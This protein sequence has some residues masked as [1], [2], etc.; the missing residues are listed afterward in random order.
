MLTDEN[1]KTPAGKENW[2]YGTVKRILQN[3]KYKGD[4]LLQK[5]Y[6]VDFLNKQQK[7]SKTLYHI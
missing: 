4:V 6:N 2:S 1:I 7:I 5:Y 3:E